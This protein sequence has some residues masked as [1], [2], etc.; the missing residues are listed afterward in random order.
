MEYI[1]KKNKIIAV[2]LAGAIILMGA[3]YAAWQDNITIKTEVSTGNLDV[4]FCDFNDEYFND[5]F[6][7]PAN[8]PYVD[9]DPTT[10][11]NVEPGGKVLSIN[12]ADLYPSK[13]LGSASVAPS[14]TPALGITAIMKNTGTIPAKFNGVN[15]NVTEGLDNLYDKIRVE[16]GSLMRIVDGKKYVYSCIF[17]EWF[18]KRDDFK[19]EELEDFEYYRENG[20]PK[21]YNLDDFKVFLD[22][23]LDNFVLNKED[24]IVWFCWGKKKVEG[25]EGLIA[26]MRFYIDESALDNTENLEGDLN[27]KFN[28]KQ[29]NVDTVVE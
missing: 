10:D 23:E 22:R 20:W 21:D 17:D 9:F 27:I 12:V 28:W 2:A 25:E 1:M 13:D 8:D 7:D 26:Q 18:P 16:R 14:E 5:A 15:I 11:V 24:E 4:Q 19:I 29:F 6:I 3:G